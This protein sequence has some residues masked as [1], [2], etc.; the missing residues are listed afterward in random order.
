MKWISVKERVPYDD[1]QVLIFGD[2]DYDTDGE[3]GIRCIRTGT[4]SK[5]ESPEYQWFTIPSQCCGDHM[6]NVS[7]WMPL[8][9][10]PNEVN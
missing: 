4:F 5:K 10:K 7:H 9:E 6:I 2:L 1:K 3:N 8:P